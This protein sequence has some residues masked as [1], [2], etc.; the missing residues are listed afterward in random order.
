MSS[1]PTRRLTVSDLPEPVAA[2]AERLPL[3]M[4]LRMAVSAIEKASTLVDTGDITPIVEW[5]WKVADTVDV[6]QY[7][8]AVARGGSHN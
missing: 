7:N 4:Q 6:A 5:L 8:A 1:R 2:Q 3:G